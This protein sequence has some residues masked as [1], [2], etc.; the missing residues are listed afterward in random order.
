MFIHIS[1][2][3]LECGGHDKDMHLEICTFLL[4]EKQHFDWL[5]H[6]ITGNEKCV[7]YVNHTQKH[8]WV[9]AEGQAE[10]E[11]KADPHQ[12]KVML[13]VWWDVHGIIHFKLLS[14]NTTITADYYC[15]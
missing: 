3:I 1:V 11:P 15:H 12:K 7:P 14:P 4:S 9:E 2:R 6:L 5:D 10:P 8:Q 13:S